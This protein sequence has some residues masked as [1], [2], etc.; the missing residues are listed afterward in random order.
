M[1]AG[2]MSEPVCRADRCAAFK[3]RWTAMDLGAVAALRR[4]YY[5]VSIVGPRNRVSRIVGGLPLLR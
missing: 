2:G 1:R 4:T 5:A 3:P